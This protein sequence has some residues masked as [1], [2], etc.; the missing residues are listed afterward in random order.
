[1]AVTC[2]SGRGGDMYEILVRWRWFKREAVKPGLVLWVVSVVLT[3]V[4]VAMLIFAGHYADLHGQHLPSLYDALHG[5]LPIVDLRFLSRIGI[6]TSV[7]LLGIGFANYPSRIPFF[8]FI[9]DF[10]LM[11]RS[12][13]MCLS[14][15]GPPVGVLLDYPVALHGT[16][17]WQFIANGMNAHC[18]LF[19]SGH[20][21]LPLLGALLF[22][23][24]RTEGERLQS[25]RDVFCSEWRQ[26]TTFTVEGWTFLFPLSYIT[27]SYIL[28]DNCYP[29]LVWCE[30]TFLWIVMMVYHRARVPLA[31]VFLIWSGVMALTVLLIRQHYTIDIY[32]AYMIT[33]TIYIIGKTLFRGLD[34]VCE[35][36]KGSQ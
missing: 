29:F 25:L 23:E 13:A 20:T 11:N 15:F 16:S 8:L 3:M 12:A 4:S 9:L 7:V 22:L 26:L 6:L 30:L 32:G 28:G 33:P 5:V 31:L 1:M 36:I 18:V 34:R 2:Q 21:S 24:N 17:W 14:V 35:K 27:I 19:F 10:W